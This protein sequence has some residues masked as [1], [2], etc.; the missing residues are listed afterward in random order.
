MT[1]SLK[2]G[3]PV[4]VTTPF[5]ISLLIKFWQYLPFGLKGT[6]KVSDELSLLEERLT[7]RTIVDSVRLW[8]ILDEEVFKEQWVRSL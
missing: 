5:M 3:S 8:N 7:Y 6:L 4:C 1:R 2:F